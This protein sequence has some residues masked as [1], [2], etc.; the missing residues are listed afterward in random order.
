MQ[1]RLHLKPVRIPVAIFG[2][3]GVSMGRQ[4]AIGQYHTLAST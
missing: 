3:L 2:S 1:L 4:A